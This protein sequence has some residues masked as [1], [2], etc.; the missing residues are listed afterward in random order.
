M[1]NP[2]SIT[3]ADITSPSHPSEEYIQS[4][5]VYVPE[6]KSYSPDQAKLDDIRAWLDKNDEILQ[7]RAFGAVWCGDCKI[8]L[9]RIAKIAKN[10]NDPRFT[11]EI[12]GNI[13]VK[14]PYARV[15]GKT[16]WKSP[17]AP[18]ETNDTRFDMF[19]IPA[20][21]I[22]NKAGRCLGKI[23]EKPEHTK[24]METEVLHYL[25]K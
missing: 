11:V 17:P 21:F 9:P 22:F 14:A 20:I 13:K 3:L 4:H 15:E 2:S 18:P 6:Y 1:F 8:Q 23:D 5:E 16:I 10:L 7:I 19:H 25:L 12:L 24:T